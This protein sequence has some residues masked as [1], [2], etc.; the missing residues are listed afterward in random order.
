[1]AKH[2]YNLNKNLFYKFEYAEKGLYLRYTFYRRSLVRH[3]GYLVFGLSISKGEHADD[4]G[5]ERCRTQRNRM[6]YFFGTYQVHI[7]IDSILGAIL[8]RI[9]Q[10]TSNRTRFCKYDYSEIGK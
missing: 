6:T 10:I 8:W 3:I 7:N 1:M 9:H 5:C 4:E 2:V